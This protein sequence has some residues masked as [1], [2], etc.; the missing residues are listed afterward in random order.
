[1]LSRKTPAAQLAASAWS[2]ILRSPW[3]AMDPA[4]CTMFPSQPGL[5]FCPDTCLSICRSTERSQQPSLRR[6]DKAQCSQRLSALA[7]GH[8]PARTYK[9]G[10]LRNPD[11]CE[12]KFTG[13][14][15][16]SLA[17]TI[18]CSPSRTSASN[19][20]DLPGICWALQLCQG[21]GHQCRSCVRNGHHH[22]GAASGHVLGSQAAE[23]CSGGGRKLA[24]T[25]AR[26]EPANGASPL[27]SALGRELLDHRGTSATLSETNPKMHTLLPPLKA[28]TDPRPVRESVVPAEDATDSSNASIKALIPSGGGGTV[29]SQGVEVKQ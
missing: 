14:L 24:R 21:R 19:S 5:L 17:G 18:P 3:E 22:L 10:M 15:W 20:S 6:P 8:L 2:L 11:T 16:L 28:D 4:G 13:S 25:R 27:L 23:C 29:P 1:M 9:E 12:D 26:Q 7:R